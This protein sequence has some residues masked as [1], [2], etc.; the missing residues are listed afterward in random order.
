MQLGAGPPAGENPRVWARGT[1]L[2]P[3]T[4]AARVR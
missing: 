4:S 2:G 1:A 3:L